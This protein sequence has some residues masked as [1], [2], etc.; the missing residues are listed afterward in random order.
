M[1]NQKVAKIEA[2]GFSAALT[3]SKELILWG[4]GEF[5]IF[6]IPQRLYMDNIKFNDIKVSKF[7]SQACA[8]ALQD[9][10]KVFAWGNNQLG[11][12]GHG[13][14]RNRKMPTQL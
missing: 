14:K 2:G 10:G 3:T 1:A 7:Q 12:L 11:Q 9:N 5:G 13:D 8:F 4:E 6:S